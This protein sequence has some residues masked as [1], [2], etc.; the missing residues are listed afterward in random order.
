MTDQRATIEKAKNEALQRVR[1]DREGALGDGDYEVEELLEIIEARLF[2]PDFDLGELRSE[3]APTDETLRRFRLRCGGSPK[4]YVTERR[5]ETARRLVDEPSVDLP[6]VAAT[7]GFADLALFSRWF[8]RWTGQT[9]K[10]RRDALPPSPCRLDVG[11]TLCGR[12][13]SSP[14]EPVETSADWLKFFVWHRARA[15]VLRRREITRL[16]HLIRLL[17]FRSRRL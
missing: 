2:H 13:P 9:P 1:D 11:A 17:A 8:K 14:S 12:P 15:R 4:S 3:C 16:I 6:D 10:S 5:L 7:L